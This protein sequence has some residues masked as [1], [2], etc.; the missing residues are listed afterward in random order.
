M[1]AM[2][3]HFGNVKIP[4][5]KVQYIFQI[6]LYTKS[7]VADSCSWKLDHSHHATR[8]NLK[9]DRLWW[10][11]LCCSFKWQEKVWFHRIV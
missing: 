2:S 6:L 3:I 1:L 4:T 8:N 10:V 11:C 7:N 5:V 9:L